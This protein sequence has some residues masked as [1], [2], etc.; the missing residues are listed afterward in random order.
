MEHIF[1]SFWKTDDSPFFPNWSSR[2]H[3]NPEQINQI[4]FKILE[5]ALKQIISQKS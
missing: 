1:R 4:A 5:E 3:K 2:T